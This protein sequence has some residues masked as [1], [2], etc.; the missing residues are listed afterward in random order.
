MR[1]VRCMSK[2]KRT[3]NV[4]SIAMTDIERERRE[5]EKAERMKRINDLYCNRNHGNNPGVTDGN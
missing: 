1:G 2:N 3:T 5:K 4:A